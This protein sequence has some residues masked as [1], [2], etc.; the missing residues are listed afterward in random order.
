MG[1]TTHRITSPVMG[2]FYRAASPDDPPFVEEGQ[3]V[4]ASEVV[5]LIE[6]MKVFTELR[7]GHAGTVKRILVENEEAVMKNQDLI[8]IEIG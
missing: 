2:T 5:C 4:D 7:A 6:S 8:E 3:K 1:E